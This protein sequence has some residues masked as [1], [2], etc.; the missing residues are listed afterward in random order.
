MSNITEPQNNKGLSTSEAKELFKKYGF[1]EIQEVSKSSVSRLLKKFIAPIPLMIEGAL[2]LSAITGR[3]EDFSIILVLLC[4]NVGVDF[5]QEQ[6]AQT[7]LKALKSVL[8]P[9]AVVLRDGVF[10]TMPARDLVPGDIVKLVLGDILPADATLV[11]DEEVSI[12]QATITGE[13]LPVTKKTGDELY[14]SS[15]VER[16]TILA[17]VTVTGH[18]TYIG[19]SAK[20]V[21]KAEMEEESHFQKAILGIGKFLILVASVLIVITFVAL[22]Y[23]GDSLIETLRF[24]LVL[25]IASIPVALP[26]VLSVTMAIGA[27]ALAKNKAIV[28][29]FVAIEELAGTDRLCVDKTGTLT[30]NEITITDPKVYGDFSLEDLSV[31]GLLASERDNKK[32]IEKTI[33]A[34]AKEHGHVAKANIYTIDDFTA[35]NP[36]DKITKVIAHTKNTRIEVIMGAPQMI[37]NQVNESNIK[38]QLA[39]DVEKLAQNGFRILA[40]A[41]KEDSVFVPVG[42]MPLLDPPREDSAS[43]IVNIKNY[44]IGIKMLTGDNTFIAKYIAGTLNIGKRIID[45]T[46]LHKIY[47]TKQT[48]DEEELVEN[49]DVFTEITPEDKY[50]IVA[51]LQSL[52]HIV[53]M[54]GDGVNDA[55]ALK[56]ADIGIAVSGASPA[57]RSAADLV[58]LG[59]GLSVIEGAIVLA[60]AT[61]SR[62]QSYATF[63]IAETIRIVFFVSFAI[64]IFNES[65][66]SAAMIILLALLN[67]IPVMA[68]AYDNAQSRESPVRWHLKETMFIS[69]LLGMTGLVSSFLLLWWLYSV[70]GVT[71]A[72]IQTVIFLKLDVSGHSTLYTTRTGRKHFWQKPFPS[73]KFFIPAFSSRI[74]GTIIVMLGILMEPIGWQAVVAIWIYSTVWFIINDQVKVFGYKIWDTYFDK[75]NKTRATLL[76]TI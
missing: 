56:K 16:G 68:I 17:L 66:L 3:W 8:T 47:A 2:I 42:I 45:A 1:N 60:R 37:L 53:A 72:I 32:T 43:V 15:I 27:H 54:T 49:S 46:Q 57:A 71:F 13:S 44:G 38:Q 39:S 20:L 14:A 6:K 63:R 7:A 61:F 40:V 50:N 51:T 5:I 70:A 25:A 10:I 55:P 24:S 36:I 35:F 58:L 67:D 22:L 28:S 21:S 41:K 30:K 64:L 9:E 69:T 12:N 19:K 18:N 65:P 29:N 74:V 48:K 26:A 11:S 75:S 23:R 62:M 73:L 4:V 59:S 31:Y 33:L 52:G 76:K 34:Y